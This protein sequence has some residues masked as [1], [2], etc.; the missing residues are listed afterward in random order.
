MVGSLIRSRSHRAL[1]QTQSRGLELLAGST[2][3]GL[4]LLQQK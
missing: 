2:G 3:L 1:R 4:T